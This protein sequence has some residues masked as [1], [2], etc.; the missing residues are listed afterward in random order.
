ML[1][2]ASLVMLALV[3][4]VASACQPAAPGSD[5]TGKTW[6]L[7][8]ITEKVPAFQ[9]A[10]PPDQQGK[11]TITFATDGTFQAQADCNQVAGTYTV[12]S[13]NAI[14]I[15]LGAS[16]LAF[17]PDG[18]LGVLFTNALATAQTYAISGSDL[19]LTRDDGGKLTPVEDVSPRRASRLDREIERLRTS[20]QPGFGPANRN[21]PP[22]GVP[23]MGI[24]S[25]TRDIIAANFNEL[26][27]QAQ[28]DGEFIFL[29]RKK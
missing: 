12:T 1:R 27:D 13:G 14:Q 19:T 3:A 26:L 21:L 22:V 6:L 24:F 10:V 11:Y 17:C 9:G 28:S 8:G 18:D 20:P 23:W 16:T 4:I 25:R 15:E 29:M 5:L 2:T 7:T